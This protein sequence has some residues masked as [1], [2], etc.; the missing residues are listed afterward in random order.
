MS[1]RLV[2]RYSKGEKVKYISHLDFMRL[3]QRALRRA[4]IPVAYSQGFNPH[5]RISFASALAVGVTSQGEYLDILLASSIDPQSLCD[6]INDKLPE[7][8]RFIES[9]SIDEKAPSLMSLI[10]RGEYLIKMPGQLF[11]SQNIVSLINRFLEQEEIIITK[12]NKRGSRQVDIK[13]M[14]HSIDVLDQNPEEVIIRTMISSGSKANLRP[15]ELVRALLDFAGTSS[16]L[17]LFLQIHRLNLYLPKNG[18]WVTPVE[19]E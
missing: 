13:E 12:V 10:E 2:V 11:G 14:I 5:P 1:M 19:L 15:E 17:E 18:S 16:D 3:I 9:V 4:D 6:R 7:G 8:I